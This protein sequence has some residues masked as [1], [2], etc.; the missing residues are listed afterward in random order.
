MDIDIFGKQIAPAL[1]IVKRFVGEEPKDFITKQYN[2]QMKLRLP[3]YG[4]ELVEIPRAKENTIGD[5]ISA[6]TVRASLKDGKYDLIG[7]MVPV[8]TLNY[9]KNN[10]ER[11]ERRKNCEHLIKQ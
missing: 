8:S 10:Y 2:E 7:K 3:R 9:L 5:V 6:S 4:I 11:L 1:G